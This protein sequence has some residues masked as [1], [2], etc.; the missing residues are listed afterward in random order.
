M[1]ACSSVSQ[2]RHHRYKHADW[3]PRL[4]GVQGK[5][6]C[7]I[8]IFCI[9]FVTALPTGKVRDEANFKVVL[10]ILGLL[11]SLFLKKCFYYVKNIPAAD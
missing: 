2:H 4:M 9:W 3:V 1:A 7:I 10:K 8:K 6:F 11:F 5:Y